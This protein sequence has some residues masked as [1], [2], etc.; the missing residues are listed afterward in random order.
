MEKA[1]SG[2][3]TV[4]GAA[5]I[6]AGQPFRVSADGRRIALIPVDGIWY[7]I[8]NQCPHKGGPLGAGAVKGT[9]ITCPW[10][11]FRFDLKTGASMTNARMCVKTYPVRLENNLIVVSVP[12][13]AKEHAN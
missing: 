1:T 5:E 13:H 11:L 7:A 8:D 6:Q 12:M 9:V 4:G 3:I 2:D 10:H